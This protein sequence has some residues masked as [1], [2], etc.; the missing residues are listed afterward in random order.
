MYGESGEGYI[1]NNT[2]LEYIVNIYP[3]SIVIYCLIRTNHFFRVGISDPLNGHIYMVCIVYGMYMLG[4]MYARYCWYLIGYL[5][6]LI[7]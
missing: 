4:I 5:L 3:I 7:I 6:F 2:A 1:R